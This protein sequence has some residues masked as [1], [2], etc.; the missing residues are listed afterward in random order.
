MASRE[1]RNAGPWGAVGGA[2]AEKTK[3]RGGYR[4][5]GALATFVRAWGCDEHI[6][7][8]RGKL[9]Q[10]KAAS[11]RRSALE[12]GSGFGGMCGEK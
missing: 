9:C 11:G 8:R 6:N 2:E 10:I 7:Q 5:R 4:R 12:L 1:A 3:Q